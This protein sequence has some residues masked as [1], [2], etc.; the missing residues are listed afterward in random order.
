M[1]DGYPQLVM[2]KLNKQMYFTKEKIQTKEKETNKNHEIKNKKPM[3]FR[4]TK[5]KKKEKKTDFFLIYNDLIFINETESDCNVTQHVYGIIIKLRS[6]VTAV[7]L[8]D[9][10]RCIWRNSRGMRVYYPS[11]NSYAV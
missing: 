3:K 4:L 7:L 10:G 11:L 5:R 6:I 8:R 2:Q 9:A 1:G